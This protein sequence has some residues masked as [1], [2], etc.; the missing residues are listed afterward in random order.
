MP[1]V[2]RN[3][4]AAASPRFCLT[5][6]RAMALIPAS[7]SAWDMFHPRPLAPLFVDVVWVRDVKI[8]ANNQY[9][10]HSKSQLFPNHN[11]TI[12]LFRMM[13]R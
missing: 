9:S 10:N 2:E 13:K 8:D 7:A 6:R 3:S 4:A 11:F 12:P 5:S 1:L